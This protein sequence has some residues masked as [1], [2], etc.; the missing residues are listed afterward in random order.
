MGTEINF[1]N[2]V[3]SSRSYKPGKRVESQFKGQ[4]GSTTF[5]QLGYLFTDAELKLQFK[6]IPD[7]Q[8]AEILDNYY[9]LQGD[10]WLAFARNDHQ[11]TGLPVGGWGGLDGDGKYGGELF[12]PLFNYVKGGY[13]HLRWRY[14]G[15]PQITSVY[16]GV[17]TVSCQFTGFLYGV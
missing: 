13:T 9:S 16:P 4:D 15:P 8:A 7:S 5:V 6:N 2:I 17:S 11:G 3:P 12:K 1:P 10:D 14:A